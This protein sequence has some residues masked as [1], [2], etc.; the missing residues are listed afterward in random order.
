[1][2]S[3]VDDLAHIRQ[4]L[5]YLDQIK[6][7]SIRLSTSHRLKA[8]IFPW[9]NQIEMRVCDFKHDFLKIDQYIYN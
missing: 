1:M 5:M 8:I 9:L 2:T 3:F 4:K 6:I 7:S